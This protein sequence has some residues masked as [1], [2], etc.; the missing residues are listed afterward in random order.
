ML[1]RFYSVM[2]VRDSLEQEGAGADVPR[3]RMFPRSDQAT[4]TLNPIST[5][6]T[7]FPRRSTFTP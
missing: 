6:Q 7:Q 3:A 4:P 5:R 1:Y 2:D